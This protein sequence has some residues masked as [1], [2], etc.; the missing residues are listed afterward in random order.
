MA[1]QPDHYQHKTLWRKIGN[2]ATAAGRQVVEKALQLHYAARRP[3]TPAWA[4]GT[5][6][7][8]IAYFILPLDA[9]PDFIPLTGYS[10]DLATLSAALYTLSRYVDDQVKE[11]AR[12]K[13]HHWFKAPGSD[14]Q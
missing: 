11:Q 9:I 3:D 12:E 1:E 6:Y 7:T 10:D 5:V 4:R 8:A 13:L 14:H 2:S